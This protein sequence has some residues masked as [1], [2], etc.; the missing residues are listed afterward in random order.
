MENAANT[1]KMRKNEKYLSK[2][3]IQSLCSTAK[4]DPRAVWYDIFRLKHYQDVSRAQR[5]ISA[6]NLSGFNKRKLKSPHK[7]VP[8]SKGVQ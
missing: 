4:G 7:G 3:I 1:R 8:I 6:L 2:G 5:L